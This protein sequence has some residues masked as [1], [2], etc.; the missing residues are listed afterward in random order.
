MAYKDLRKSG[1]KFDD[2]Y[3]SGQW[4]S[5]SYSRD[6]LAEKYGL[7]T[8]AKENKGDTAVWGT[9]RAG[10]RV[11]LGNIDN[12]FRSNDD[13]IQAHLRQADAGE[14]K[15]GAVP[16]AVSSN[17][18]VIG[19]MLNM[20]DGGEA[21][22]AK[23]KPKEK[24]VPSLSEVDLSPGF[25]GSVRRDMQYWEDATDGGSTERVFGRKGGPDETDD[26]YTQGRAFDFL[27]NYKMNLKP[28]GGDT[29]KNAEKDPEDEE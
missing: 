29:L 24:P 15:H 19:A 13:V 18:D 23:E 21:G 11:F 17:G 12:S 28:E 10:K 9:N 5:G 22:P 20:W 14:S 8:S 16:E 26:E 1:T 25:V 4:G 3:I 6:Q 27:K 2:K 7:D